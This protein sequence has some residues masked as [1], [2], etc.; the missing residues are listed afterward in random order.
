MRITARLARDRA[1]PEPLARIK[2]GAF[3]APVV[4]GKRFGSRVLEEQLAVVGTVQ[5]FGDDRIDPRAIHSRTFEK[6]DV[7]L[8]DRGHLQIL[9]TIRAGFEAAN[10]ANEATPGARDQGR[11]GPGPPFHLR[12]RHVPARAIALSITN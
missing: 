1:Q 6:Q 3:Q 7:G 9:L 4:E 11:S 10:E 8:G 5:R 2:R 12:P